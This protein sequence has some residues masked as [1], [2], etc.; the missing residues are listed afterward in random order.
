MSPKAGNGFWNSTYKVRIDIFIYIHWKGRDYKL[1]SRH[2]M[3]NVYWKESTSDG[4]LPS[5]QKIFSMKQISM[6]SISGSSCESADCFNQLIKVRRADLVNLWLAF[7]R[8]GLPCREKADQKEITCLGN[9]SILWAGWVEKNGTNQCVLGVNVNTRLREA[10]WRLKMWASVAKLY[11]H[12]HCNCKQLHT[13][14]QRTQE[15]TD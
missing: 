8:D 9:L 6:W 5:E 4:C 1:I 7:F 12:C 14:K 13:N 2:T 15:T 3:G 10:L 11:F